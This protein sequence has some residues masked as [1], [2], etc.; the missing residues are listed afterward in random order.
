MNVLDHIKTFPD[1]PVKGINFYDLNSLFVNP[2]WPDII[3]N[4]T[5][6]VRRMCG[7]ISHF[8]GIESR[9]FV[10]GAALAQEMKLPFCM[11]RKKGSKYPGDLLEESYTLEYGTNTLV[12]QK[13]VLDSNS[14]VVIVDDLVATGGSLLASQKLCEEFGASVLANTAMI[15]LSY[16]K[17]PEKEKLKNLIVIERVLPLVLDDEILVDEQGC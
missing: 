11:I 17:T 14:R 4:T 16:I 6:E 3:G 1:Y 8:V 13:D 2:V 9:G 10:Y 7:Y 12:L 15:D 5:M